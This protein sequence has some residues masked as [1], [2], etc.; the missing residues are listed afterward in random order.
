MR[1]NKYVI[2]MVVVP[3]FAVFFQVVSFDFLKYDDTINIS[4]N[5]LI[6]NPSLAHVL[7]FWK[8]AFL[9]LYIPVTYTIWSGLGALSLAVF[10]GRL[11]PGMFHLFNLLIHALNSLL[12]FFII[13]KLLILKWKDLRWT[14]LAGAGIFGALIFGLHPVQVETVAWITGLKGLLSGFFALGALWLFLVYYPAEKKCLVYVLSTCFFALALLSMPSAVCLP[15]MLFLILLWVEPRITP[16]KIYPLLPWCAVAL[17]VI[18]A[19]RSAQPVGGLLGDYPWAIRPLVALD[20]VMF[21]IFQIIWPNVLSIDYCRTPAYV[22]GLSWHN[23]YLW[24]WLPLLG[25]A[26]RLRYRPQWLVLGCAFLAGILP[27]SGLLPFGFQLTS[28]VAD[29]YLYFSMMVVTLALS[30]LVVKNPKPAIW[31]LC[32]LLVTA[33]GVRS[34]YQCRHW[35]NTAA[36]MKHTLAYYPCSFRANLN[37]GIAL[38]S[39]GD[40]RQAIPFYKTA[41]RLRPDDPLPYYNLGVAYAGIND[42]AS[43]KRQYKKLSVMDKEKAVRLE[44]AAEAFEALYTSGKAGS[45]NGKESGSLKE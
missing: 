7:K 30:A 15:V 31:A 27:V 5:V 36:I 8:A 42:K 2:L 3:V 23:P 24:L 12:V 9:N 39:R 19:T 26:W 11:D 43:Y 6:L 35:K 14:P 33:A 13:R 10:N 32:F 25:I 44:A 38:T 37:Y 4:E 16:R 28:T 1:I 40:F 22:V 41:Q 18:L 29:R 45:R 20:A 34:F 21:Y 17:S